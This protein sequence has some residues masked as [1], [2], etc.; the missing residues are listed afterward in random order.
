MKIFMI[1]IGLV[2]CGCVSQPKELTQE[3]S[4]LHIYYEEPEIDYESLGRVDATSRTN[5]P[6]D[7]LEG[8]LS[9]AMELGADAVLIHSIHNKGGVLSRDD[10]FGTGGASS[11]G[12]YQIKATAIRYVN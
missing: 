6:V 3:A 10:A 5:H 7:M 12:V 8:I 11:A 4:N 1:L 2:I 9:R